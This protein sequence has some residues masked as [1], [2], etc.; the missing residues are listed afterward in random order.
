[1]TLLMAFCDYS[2]NC[3]KDVVS[4][5]KPKSPPVRIL[6]ATK[7]EKEI[8]LE[9][10]LPSSQTLNTGLMSCELD[11]AEKKFLEEA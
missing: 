9:Y 2:G 5:P 1:M 8:A 10:G 11:Q 3:I 4:A 6:T 7:D